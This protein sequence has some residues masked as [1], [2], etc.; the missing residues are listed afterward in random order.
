MKKNWIFLA[1]LLSAS[2]LYLG[3]GFLTGGGIGEDSFSGKDERKIHLP[4]PGRVV[5]DEET[6]LQVEKDVI[7]VTFSKFAD[8]A[9]V[10][11]IAAEIGGDIVG[12]E[13]DS[14][15]Y[16]IKIPAENLNETKKICLNLLQ[17]YKDVEYAVPN[18]ISKADNPYWDSKN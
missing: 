17:N 6:G 10:D 15:F 14:G 5:T 16:Q 9:M 18:T 4:D 8:D 12:F 3:Y 11:K 13:R 2:L 7:I 1:V